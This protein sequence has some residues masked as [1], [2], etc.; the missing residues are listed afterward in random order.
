MNKKTS[1]KDPGK[2]TSSYTG[3]RS[4]K[5]AGHAENEWMM[6]KREH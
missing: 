5:S 6:M 2:G 4:K 1:V 3:C